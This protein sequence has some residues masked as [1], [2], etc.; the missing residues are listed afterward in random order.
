MHSE[1]F[2]ALAKVDYVD[3]NYKGTAASVMSVASGET[4]FGFGDQASAGPLLKAGKIRLLAIGSGK[5]S[6][7]MPDVPTMAESGVVGYDASSWTGLFAPVKTPRGVVD[8]INADVQRVLAMPDVKQ[9]FKNAEIEVQG[10]TPEDFQ[11]A[12]KE[13]HDTWGQLAR[14]RNII[15]D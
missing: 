6:A 1:L 10:G 14:D 7:I 11:R 13:A 5:R 4:Q 8:K 3:I 15:F 9:W 2:K 12:V